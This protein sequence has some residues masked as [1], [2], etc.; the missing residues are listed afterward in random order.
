[1]CRCVFVWACVVC[2]CDSVVCYSC[3]TGHECS[4]VL[5]THLDLKGQILAN[6]KAMESDWF[7]QKYMGR[8][9]RVSSSLFSV[10]Q[11]RMQ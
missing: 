8:K 6:L 5:L 1:M 9:E 7:C 4:R 2:V 10:L 3:S 11:Q